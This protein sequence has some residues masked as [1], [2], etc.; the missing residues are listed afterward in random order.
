MN[1]KSIKLLKQLLELLDTTNKANC[2]KET[3][4]FI[5]DFNAI[6]E[7]AQQEKLSEG[8]KETGFDLE[9][10]FS[11]V[12]FVSVDTISC[13]D[14]PNANCKAKSVPAPN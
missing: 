1:L 13:E 14:F 4:Q 6:L 10:M 8:C 5:K 7:E 9:S 3:A 2:E 11:P 12:S